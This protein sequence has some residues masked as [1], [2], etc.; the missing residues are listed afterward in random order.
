MEATEVGP[1]FD[2]PVSYTCHFRGHSDVRHALAIGTQRITPEISFELV[3]EAVLTQTHSHGGGHPKGAPKPRVAV[4]RELGGSPELPRLLGREIEATEL[5]ELAMVV[6]AAQVAGF[7]Q[8]RERQDGADA[9]HLLKTFEV[10]VVLEVTRSSLLQL[11]AELTESDHLTEHDAE[12][13]NRF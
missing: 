13:R 1:G 3:S 11:I 7:G 10:G 9:R 2:D 6:E 4:L 5:E 8:D 12:H